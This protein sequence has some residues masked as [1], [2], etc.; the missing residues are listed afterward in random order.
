MQSAALPIV[1]AD[2]F[3]LDFQLWLCE[4]QL[5]TGGLSWPV[6]RGNHGKQGPVTGPFPPA[7]IGDLNAAAGPR[8]EG[9]S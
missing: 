2:H 6:G 1:K 4:M 5:S 8:P 3:V 9:G 7:D